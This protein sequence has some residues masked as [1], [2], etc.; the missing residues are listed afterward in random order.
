MPD[1]FTE[2]PVKGK[3]VHNTV[4]TGTGDAIMAL[5]AIARAG[6]SAVT[7][8]NMAALVVD[9]TTGALNVAIV[10]GGS[11]ATQTGQFNTVLPTMTSGTTGY[12]QLDASGRQIVV[13]GGVAGTPAG[14]V[15]TIQGITGGTAIPISGSVTATISGTVDVSDRA[16][17][18]LGVVTGQGVA[19]TPAGGVVSIQ[20]VAG[21]TALPVSGAFFQATQPV[22][23]ATNT[24]DVTDRSGR[25]LGV[26][27]ISAG[28]A[29]I[30]SVTQG[31]AA[32]ITAPW[33][34]RL[35]DG[36]AAIGTSANPLFVTNSEGVAG[37]LVDSGALTS[38]SVA[39]AG[40]ANLDTAAVTA[41]PGRL[42][43]VTASSSVACKV[44][45]MSGPAAGPTVRRVFFIAAFG[46]L[47]FAPKDVDEITTAVGDIFRLRFT[48]LDNATTADVYGSV[49]YVK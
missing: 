21:G 1:T 35:S 23:L 24:P 19:G 9:A 39:P 44:E 7:A 5:P 47:L 28:A 13:G 11:A 16:A 27:S 25:L 41:T 40:T 37:T 49:T 10:S 29:A 4:V 30:G 32:A 38:A 12:A 17:R 18:V 45:V 48:N 26:V 14:G 2:T 22:S 33:P 46:N 15:V 43:E 3:K 31:T 6:N 8:G 20:G 34:V 36:T 42:V